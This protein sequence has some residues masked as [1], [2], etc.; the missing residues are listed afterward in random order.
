[1]AQV[2]TLIQYLLACNFK[3]WRDNGAQFIRLTFSFNTRAGLL[4]KGILLV[5]A[6][7]KAQN[8]SN[9]LN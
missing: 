1:M 3:L 4:Y 5:I 9:E 7:L 8:P 6:F 2:G